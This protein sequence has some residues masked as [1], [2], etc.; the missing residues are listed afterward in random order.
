M[1]NV[2]LFTVVVY[3]LGI[4]ALSVFAS[5]RIRSEEDYIVAGR[6][7]PLWMAWGT[8]LATWFGA[9]TILGSAEA[10]R[11]EGVRGTILDPFASGISLV[12]AGLFFAKPLW[13]MKLLTMGDF[14]GRVYGQRTEML[15]SC[16]LVPGYFGW[17]GAQFVALAD[18]QETFFGIAPSLGIATAAGFILLYTL[19][20]G[21]WSVTMTDTLQ[22]VVLL[23]GI[24]IL[25]WAVFSQLGDGSLFRGVGKLFGETEPE[26]LTLL[27]EAG[28]V[29]S[30]AW[31]ATVGSGV[32]GNIP[33][34]DL[35]QRVF[36]SRDS[37]TA[38]QA[39][40]L[41]GVAYI[42]FG[43]LPVGMGLASRILVTA[44]GD[45][46]IL[47]ILANQ[48]LTPTLMIVFV[49]S[50][51]S[52]IVSTATSAVL[53]PATVLGHNL[54]AKLRLF[55]NR[56]LFVE[57]LAVV[58]MVAGGVAMAFTG[59]TI[60]GLL[61]SALTTVLVGLF[62]PLVMGLYGKPRGELSGLLAIAFG[63]VIWFLREVFE[64]WLVPMDTTSSEAGLAYPDYLR[65]QFPG[66]LGTLMC[67]IAVLPS[68]VAGVSA[69]LVGYAVGQ[70][71]AGGPQQ[72]P[73][74]SEFH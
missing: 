74:Q 36:A 8:L 66:A 55:R 72:S 10:A 7:L 68:V 29:A 73:S 60:L 54:I 56:A 24:V 28:I 49:V 2:L 67:M 34:Q 33:G 62:V 71:M 53:A 19:F 43:I 12:V 63:I 1:T 38:Q 15:A 25:G 3:L 45:G 46:A 4:L 48:F 59:K 22:A 14:Y 18:L 42:A 61:E 51:V 50:L 40:V 9:A 17:I 30:M 69:S 16:V 35:M 47:A 57:R 65:D 11:T 6:R 70:L 31:L 32:F 5:Q 41:A 44:P 13:E 27:P 37:K 39:C 26:M 52:I 64:A 20:G 58:L 23:V 21:M